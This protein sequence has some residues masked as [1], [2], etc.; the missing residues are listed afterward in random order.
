MLIVSPFGKR[1]CIGLLNHYTIL[2]NYMISNLLYHNE[3]IEIEKIIFIIV[4][5]EF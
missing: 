4:I 5:I 1:I 2:W 3:S